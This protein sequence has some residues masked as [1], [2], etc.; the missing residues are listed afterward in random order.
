[1]VISSRSSQSAGFAGLELIVV[2]V[3]LGLVGFLAYQTYQG[4]RKTAQPIATVTPSLTATPHATLTPTPTPVTEGYL[5]IKELDVRIKLSPAIAD[6]EYVYMNNTAYF[7]S[8]SLT[9]LAMNSTATSCL[10]DQ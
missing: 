1:M 3:V 5:T 6:L 2:V 10:T 9:T 8:R 4:N 7:G